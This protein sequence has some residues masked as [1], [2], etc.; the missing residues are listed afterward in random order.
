MSTK[1]DFSKTLKNFS[2]T[3]VALNPNDNKAVASGKT[4]KA[5]IEEA[6]EKGVGN[7]IVT[8]VPKN[9]GAYIL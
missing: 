2:S 9:Y 1:Q 6:R 8:R 5:V 7:P 3:W 4:P